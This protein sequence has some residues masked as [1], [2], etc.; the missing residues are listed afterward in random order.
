M[1]KQFTGHELT[2]FAKVLYRDNKAKCMNCD[3]GYMLPMSKNGERCNW[4]KCN[5]CGDK[6]HFNYAI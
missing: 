1:K 4:Y 6:F 3:G 2:E 5:K